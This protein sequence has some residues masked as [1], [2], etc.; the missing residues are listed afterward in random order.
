[1]NEIICTDQTCQSLLMAKGAAVFQQI[2]TSPYLDQCYLL[3][4]VVVTRVVTDT[5][6]MHKD[7]L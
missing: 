5:A 1:M 4:V 2:N 7:S 3:A 6:V